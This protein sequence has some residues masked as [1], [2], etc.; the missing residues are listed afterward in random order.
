MSEPIRILLG[1]LPVLLRDEVR[2]AL[3]GQQDI[4]IVGEPA[5]ARSLVEAASQKHAQVA[6]LFDDTDE[7][8]IVDDLLA[9]VPE[10]KLLVVATGGDACLYELA[11][12]EVRL[13]KVGPEELARVIEESVRP[14]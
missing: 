1:C 5:D 4:E 2:S 12:R 8:A 3:A 10:M 6:V 13:G 11:R 14:R 7:V 9:C